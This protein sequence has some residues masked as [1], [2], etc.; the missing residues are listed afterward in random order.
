[1]CPK[2]RMS[3][4]VRRKEICE[5]AKKV[6]LRKGFQ[7]TTMEGVI[8]EV[9]MSKGGVYNYYKNTSDMLYDIMIQGNEQRFEQIG[10]FMKKHPDLSNEE[11]AIELTILKIFDKNEYKSIYAMFL[12]ESEKDERLKKLQIKIFKDSKKEFLEFIESHNLKRLSCLV[13][14]EFI[15]LINSM[16]VAT[17]VL[18]VRDTFLKRSDLFRDIIS[19]YIEKN[20]KETTK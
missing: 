12:I 16:I 18:D 2:Q 8:N 20:N 3:A 7:N 19:S 14:D 11:L 6:F 10:D 13:N 1:M 9:G 15:A 4:E 5:A 17:E